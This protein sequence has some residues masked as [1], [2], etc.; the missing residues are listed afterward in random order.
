MTG[1][2][3]VFMAKF[4][5]FYMF[6]FSIVISWDSAIYYTE[7]IVFISLEGTLT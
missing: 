6:I 3:G 5:S 2:Y 7:M 4:Q 1:Q